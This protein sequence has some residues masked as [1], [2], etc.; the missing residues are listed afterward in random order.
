[1]A[2]A[3]TRVGGRVRL[4]PELA[5]VMAVAWGLYALLTVVRGPAGS[6]LAFSTLVDRAADDP[7]YRF[8]WLITN[9]NDAQFYSS[10]FGGIA[11]VAGAFAAWRLERVESRWQGFAIAAGTGLWPQV[12]AASLLGLAISVVLYG[13]ILEDG[14][15]IPT[16]VPFV[17]IPAG[18]V[19]IY[20]PGWRNLL[21]G[22]I[23]G[24]VI[25][26]P[27]AYAVIELLLKPIGFP[28]VIAT[29]PECGWAAS[30]C[31]SFAT[32]CCR[33]CG[34]RTRR[35]RASSPGSPSR[36]ARRLLSRSTDRAGWR[37]AR[38]PTSPRPSSTATRS[39]PPRCWA[40]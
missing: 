4:L 1:M 30:S 18:V 22:A 26:F 5:A 38:S 34:H 2:S 36:S 13:S 19:L 33:G 14:A 23:L 25:G 3:R 7:W 9:T 39:R 6:L 12:L 17:S 40:A 15:W 21:T 16:F 29:S 24:G 20:G 10:I 37:A 32:G 31:S 11:L 8:L 27:I 28:A 35:R